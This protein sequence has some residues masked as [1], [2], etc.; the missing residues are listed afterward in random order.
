MRTINENHTAIE[1]RALLER[2]ESAVLRMRLTL[3]ELAKRERLCR[4]ELVHFTALLLRAL[5][6][7]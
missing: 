6:E 3:E 4:E 7:V 1:E 2:R 5:E